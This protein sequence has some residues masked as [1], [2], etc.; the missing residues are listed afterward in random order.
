MKAP[1]VYN[2]RLG[3]AWLLADLSLN[4]WALSLVKWLG[5]DFPAAQVVFLR[6]L[7]G[8]FLILPL[9]V[10]HREKFRKIED[11]NLHILR[12][13]LAVV[14]LTA[15]FFAIA[16]VPLALFTAISFTRP[17]ITMLMAAALLRETIGRR[18]WAAAGIAL[19]GVYFAV[20]PGG[21][22]WNIGIAALGLVVLTASGTVIATR[23]LREA[24]SIVLMTFYTA[25]LTL[26][27]V[28]FALVL[29]VPIEGSS[30]VAF[31][32]IGAFSQAAQLC[33]LKAH[34]HGTAGFLSVLSYLSLVLSVGVGYFVFAEVPNAGFA[35][36]ALLV[37]GAALWVTLDPREMSRLTKAPSAPR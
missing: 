16:R 2:N 32:F 30:L 28:P 20:D 8:F 3:G 13:A 22:D 15:S 6:A 9:I 25:G 12:V 17:L 27:S 14:T 26:F 4:I 37:V 34:Y 10:K 19:I 35:F 23:K 18:K 33:F 1:A 29:W 31:L 36:G 24:P 5:A 7:I 11:L 21:G